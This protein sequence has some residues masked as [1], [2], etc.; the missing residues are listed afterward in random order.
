[1][2]THMRSSN[3]ACCR[4]SEPGLGTRNLG[5]GNRG[6]GTRNLGSWGPGVRDPRS[7]VLG[8]WGP[9]TPDLGSG[10]VRRVPEGVLPRNGLFGGPDPIFGKKARN[11]Q[12]RPKKAK[13]GQKRGPGSQNLA[14]ESQKTAKKCQKV[15]KKAKKCRF[16]DPC[17]GTPN[18]WVLR[19]KKGPK[20]AKKGVP[21]P[22]T[23]KTPKKPE[24]AKKG[25]FLTFR[26]SFFFFTP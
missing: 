18:S 19:P 22:Q 2:C 14:P 7:G 12:K 21:G 8:V 26:A 11:G 25:V 23:P 24:F 20:S 5:S 16:W 10:G 3:L 1:M 17:S 9:G 6:L 13:K 15:P 4:C